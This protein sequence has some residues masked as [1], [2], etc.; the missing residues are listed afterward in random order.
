M[1]NI[2]YPS[3]FAPR[4]LSSR[5]SYNDECGQIY[6]SQHLN[7]VQIAEKKFLTR[8]IKPLF[9]VHHGAVNGKI[10]RYNAKKN[11]IAQ[12]F[13]MVDADAIKNPSI[14]KKSE[15]KKLSLKGQED[16]QMQPCKPKQQNMVLNKSRTTCAQPQTSSTVWNLNAKAF[17]PQKKQESEDLGNADFEA[18]K[19]SDLKAR[20][21]RRNTSA[22]LL[23][24]SAAPKMCTEASAD[25]DLDQT[26]SIEENAEELNEAQELARK[27]ERLRQFHQYK[28]SLTDSGRLYCH[29]LKDIQE[30][31]Q[32]REL[33]DASRKFGE[34]TLNYAA[35]P[36]EPS[37]SF[38]RASPVT[39]VEDPLKGHQITQEFRTKMTD[40]MIEVTTSFKCQPRTYFLAVTLLDK[41][42][43]AAHN[44]GRMLENKD[45]HVLGVT[46]MYLASKYEDVF[47][48]H[49]KVVSEKIAHGAISPKQIT[50]KEIEFLQLFEF[51]IDFV[52]HYDFW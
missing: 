14:V 51:Q 24:D 25:E 46:A 31:L 52:T 22:D 48:L 35:R 43:I 44:N 16:A 42:L 26:D 18:V 12:N 8:A 47:P 15:C 29:Q 6:Q 17:Y 10:A 30:T 19:M 33:I 49:S 7:G 3:S 4:P 1:G 13:G 34:A 39:A 32:G 50:E 40:W 28:N 21:I 20:P 36:E 23:D 38:S 2:M 37:S 5:L 11:F 27:Q 9:K 41:Y 45:I